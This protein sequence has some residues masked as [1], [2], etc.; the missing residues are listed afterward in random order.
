[1]SQNIRNKVVSSAESR[2]IMLSSVV[3][4]DCVSLGDWQRMRAICISTLRCVEGHLGC[5]S[6]WHHD[7]VLFQNNR[8]CMGKLD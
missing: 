6:I 7:C 5:K 2:E 8:L 1:M 3:I 4:A